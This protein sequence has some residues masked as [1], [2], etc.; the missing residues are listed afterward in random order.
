MNRPLEAPG[1]ASTP[2]DDAGARAVVLQSARLVALGVPHGFSTRLGG[3]STGPFATLNLALA[4]GDD[5][6]AV[7]T[8]LARFSRAIGV[9][10]GRLVQTSQ[11]HGATVRVVGA[12]DDPRTV[13]REE[14][15]ALVSRDSEIPI[16]VRVADCVPI[17]LLDERTGHVAAV[18]AG[19]R[20]VVG[21]VLASAVVTLIDHAA[22]RPRL[23]AAIG[24]CIGPCCFEV[25]DEV[26]VQ[27]ADAAP[28][29]GAVV[30]RNRADGA[31]P[32]VDLR[33][34]VRLQLRALGVD[35]G[36]IEDVAGC[37]RCDTERFFSFRR[38]G[39]R[40]GRH[41]AAIAPAGR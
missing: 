6:A 24:P 12:G 1:S 36:S 38:D 7:A 33:R 32:H 30:L 13:V 31:K 27:L 11:V 20:G 8:N 2:D 37:T 23:T 40:S 35:D 29:D 41:I 28:G 16:G 9:P 39:A 22:G 17:L 26:A 15:D 34:A 18:H 4:P 3:V 19:W 14:A 21:G 25:G 5:P 10:A